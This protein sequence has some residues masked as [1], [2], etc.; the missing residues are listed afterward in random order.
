MPPYREQTM[1]LS[2]A[3]LESSRSAEEAD[4]LFS[5]GARERI[6]SATSAAANLTSVVRDEKAPRPAAATAPAPAPAPATAPAAR[7]PATPDSP[8]AAAAATESGD[9]CYSSEECDAGIDTADAPTQA[10]PMMS[11]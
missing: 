7:A 8:A 9:S 6:T 1:A 5:S 11:L 2:D 10:S 4:S 3:E